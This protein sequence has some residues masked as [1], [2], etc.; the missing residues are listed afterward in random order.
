MDMNQYQQLARETAIY[1]EKNTFMG[2]LYCALGLGEAGEFQ[3]KVKKILRGDKTYEESRDS[4]VD[5]LGD[6][7]WYIANTAEELGISLDRLAFGNLNKLRARKAAGTLQGDGD[8][9]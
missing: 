1:P 8:Q 3:G 4:L 7:L 9:R 2:L 5:E 6:Q